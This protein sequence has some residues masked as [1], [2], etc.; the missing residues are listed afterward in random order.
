M[1]R[2]RNCA[3]VRVSWSTVW[4]LG[5]E[6]F[7]NKTLPGQG[8]GRGAR[9]C[10]SKCWGLRGAEAPGRPPCCTDP[11]PL[12]QSLE[13][14]SAQ[15]SSIWVPLLKEGRAHR[16]VSPKAA[17]WQLLQQRFTSAWFWGW[18]SKNEVPSWGM[19]GTSPLLGFQ[20]A[21]CLCVATPVSV[22]TGPSP[23]HR[24]PPAVPYLT[25]ILPQRPIFKYHHWQMF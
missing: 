4:T 17:G 10:C 15:R 6:V 5:W 3:T 13:A 23:N 25:G 20:T 21:A 11:R 1:I 8:A 24:V 22:C 14:G 19:F 2:R 9:A 12:R 7:R 16:L 18:Q